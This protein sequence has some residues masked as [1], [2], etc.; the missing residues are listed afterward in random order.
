MAKRWTGRRVIGAAIALVIVGAIGGTVA[1]RIAQEDQRRPRRE[2]LP[3]WSCSSSRP[4]ISPGWMRSPCRAG[5]RSPG[6]CSRC[7][8]R[9][10][11]AKVSGDVRQ[12]PGAGR[13]IRARRPVAGAH[14]HRRPR[15][16]AHRAQR[17][18]RIGEGPARDG[19]QDAGDQPGSS[20]S[21]TSFRR[22]RTTI[23]NRASGC[24]R[25]RSSRR[26][27]RS[28][29]PATRCA[30]RS[31]L[32]PARGRG[33]Q[34]PRSGRR[35]GRV[36]FAARHRR[37]P[38]RHGAAGR[39]ARRRRSGARDRQGRRAHDRRLRRA[40]LHRARRADQSGRR[41]GNARH[42]C[43]CRNPEC[44][45]ARSA[46]ACSPP[47]GSRSRQ[48]LRCRRCRQRPCAPRPDR[49]SCGRSRAASS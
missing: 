8:R 25:A 16:E 15:G 48:A 7:G 42:P 10:S 14:R 29:S 20:S 5:F 28:S 1:M 6:R 24:R 31:R 44:R 36:R 49:R 32:V 26:R 38:D 34:A 39:G 9:R 19:R 21:R 18:A 46:A 3:R 4:P 37:R 13:R 2:E 43:I 47:A 41:A 35:E 23:P 17:R 45:R 12:V 30:M 40:P 27:P 22:T 33:R 11:K